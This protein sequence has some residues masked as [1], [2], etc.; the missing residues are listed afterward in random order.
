[1]SG[2]VSRLPSTRK[3]NVYSVL[4]MHRVAPSAPPAR[5]KGL[6]GT[7]QTPEESFA[8][9][10]LKMWVTVAIRTGLGYALVDFECL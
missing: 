1:L 6:P 8:L 4:G 2:I 3:R 5:E 9:Y 10:I 7:S